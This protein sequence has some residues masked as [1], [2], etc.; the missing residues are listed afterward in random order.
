MTEHPAQTALYILNDYI[1]SP[2]DALLDRLRELLEK[3]MSM[4]WEGEDGPATEPDQ[5][6]EVGTNA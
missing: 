5:E 4:P 6:P 1:E 2:S 3:L